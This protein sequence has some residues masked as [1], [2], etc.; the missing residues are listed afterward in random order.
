MIHPGERFNGWTH[1]I[2]TALALAG[3]PLL[4]RAAARTGEALPVVSASVY[5]S[6]LVLLFLAST[7]FHTFTG[8]AKEIFQILDHIAIFLLIAGTYTPVALVT[9]GGALGWTMFGLTWG[10]AAVGT[11]CEVVSWRYGRA[12][13]LTLYVVMGWLAIGA[14]SRV[15]EGLGTTG[16]VLIIVGGAL[17][18]VGIVFYAWRSL[19]HSHGI[20]HLFVLGG[21]ACHFA[22]IV[23]FG[24]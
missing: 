3:L 1:L 15:F 20:W 24:F 2:G 7:L 12:V 11:V 6:T 19:P 4:F 10:L 16:G 23:L 18:T 22:A 17:Y 14:V 13:A 9:I 21:S 8:R 5:G